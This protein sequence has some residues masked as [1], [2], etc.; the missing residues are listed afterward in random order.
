M[1]L[2]EFLE[3]GLF[4]FED[5]GVNVSYQLSVISYQLSVISYQL[6]V[7]SFFPLVTGN[8]S[9]LTEKGESECQRSQAGNAYWE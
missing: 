3:F 8:C 7:I 6:S 2:L 1:F 5:N 4:V 9:L